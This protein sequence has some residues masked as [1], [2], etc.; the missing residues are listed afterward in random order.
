MKNRW[1]LCM[2][3]LERCREMGLD[4]AQV[5]TAIE[6]AEVTWS[7]RGRVV[8]ALGNIA[9]VFSREGNVVVTVLWRTQDQYA[10]AA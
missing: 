6:D 4:R 8:A 10:R 7:S 2:H 1:F 3:A 9:V 5:V